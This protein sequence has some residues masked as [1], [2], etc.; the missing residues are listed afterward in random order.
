MGNTPRHAIIVSVYH[1][2]IFV[3]SGA[4]TILA[5]N[6]IWIFGHHEFLILSLSFGALGGSLRASREVV[7]AVKGNVY[8]PEL[9]L[10]QVLTPIQGAVL[11]AVG[12]V[13][14]KG[15][16]LSLTA[17]IKNV[18]TFRYF[19]MGVS[20]FI[21]FAS[22]LFIKQLYRSAAALFGDPEKYRNAE[23]GEPENNGERE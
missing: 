13:L 2:V 6:R 14:I 11:A 7:R 10:W 23:K 12:Y 20:F 16:L 21:G 4:L 9:L 5:W 19:V 17:G 15:G 3:V 1:L 8:K 18:E 22:E